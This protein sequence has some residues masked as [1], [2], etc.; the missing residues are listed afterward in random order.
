MDRIVNQKKIIYMN[1]YNSNRNQNQRK[2][3]SQGKKSE[4]SID[5]TNPSDI[6]SKIIPLLDKEN[7]VF[8]D[9]KEAVQ[10]IES[11][12]KNIS[13]LVR[14]D[15]VKAHQ[16]RNIYNLIKKIKNREELLLN[17]PRL[18]YIGA[19]QATK[20]GKLITGIILGLVDKVIEENSSEIFKKKLNGLIYIMESIVAYH[21]FYINN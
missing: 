11:T 5:S 21:K 19:R 6:I 18:A 16:I 8:E 2:F 17:K 1:Q 4:N 3:D 13:E 15:K 14:E 10:T 12:L 20:S 7:H 9:I